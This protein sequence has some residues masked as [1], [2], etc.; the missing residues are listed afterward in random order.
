MTKE[1]SPAFQFYPKDWMSDI[2]TRCMTLEEC[3]AYVEL[4]CVEWLEKGLPDDD[5]QLAVISRLGDKWEK[6][7]D[8]IKKCFNKVGDKL[9]HPRL[10]KERAKQKKRREQTSAAGRLGG[11]SRKTKGNMVKQTLSESLA[12]DEA[13]TNPSSSFSSSTSTANKKNKD[14]YGNFKNVKLLPEEHS[15]LI[16]QFGEK[17]T[18]D[19]INRLSEYI[20]GHGKEKKYKSHYA[21]ILNWSRRD[22]EKEKD[23][24]PSS[25]KDLDKKDYGAGVPDDGIIR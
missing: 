24:P 22:K 21:V 3:G 19:F 1:K 18:L 5:E 10:K 12:N 15:K 20:S 9:I 23:K 8:K 17:G 7:G 6:S 2:N 14:I 4:L 11:M 13:K 25:H 16:E